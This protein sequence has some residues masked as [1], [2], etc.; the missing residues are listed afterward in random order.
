MAKVEIE[1][2]PTPIDLS[3]IIPRLPSADVASLIIQVL[4]RSIVNNH[5][6][7]CAAGILFQDHPRGH[8][9]GWLLDYLDR[10]PGITVNRKRCVALATKQKKQT[11]RT[12]LATVRGDGVDV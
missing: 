2:T 11:P 6:P 8:G 10:L 3:K 4:T 1:L 7:E 9:S 12:E 5:S